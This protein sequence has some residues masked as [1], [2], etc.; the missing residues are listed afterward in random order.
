MYLKKSTTKWR[1]FCLGLNVL[2]IPASRIGPICVQLG[3]KFDQYDCSKNLACHDIIFDQGHEVQKNNISMEIYF[4]E[5]K[6][7]EAL[8]T[9][10]RCYE[11]V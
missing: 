2:L 9:A 11:W 8:P 10:N 4:I 7:I 5:S 3:A 1:P 6:L